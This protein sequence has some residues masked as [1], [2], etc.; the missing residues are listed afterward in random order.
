M[1]LALFASASL[2]AA[3]PPPRPSTL[4]LSVRNDSPLARNAEIAVGGVPLPRGLDI[5]ST[6]NLAVTTDSG[7]PIPATFRI[8][9]RWNAGLDDVSAPVQ[10]L[11]VRF[12]ASLPAQS[13]ASFRLRYDGSIANP[14]P[15]VSLTL[16]Q[17]GN[18]IT[19][20]TGTASFV[21]DGSAAQVL[22]SADLPNGTR[23]I[24]SGS[25]SST[26]NGSTAAGFTSLRRIVVEH[27][28]ALSAVV[29]VEGS[30]AHPQISNGAV[31]GGRR[32]VFHAGS[33]AVSVREW[34]DWEGS[35]CG[36]GTVSCAGA[37]DAV[38]LN[39]WR[40]GLTP[41]ALTGSRTLMSK[42]TI[43]QPSSS[44]A[45]AVGSTAALR[46][47]RR[48]N[49]QSAQQYSLSLPGSSTSAGERADAAV[50]ALSGNNGRVAI[51][52]KQ[53]A[54]HEPQALR[55][56]A[57]GTLALDLA[58]DGVWLGQRQGTSAEYRI[59][60]YPASSSDTSV[61]TEQWA[62]LEQP[63]L[64][65]PAA[66]W[67]AASEATDE[68]PV[69]TLPASLASY[70]SALANLITRTVQLRRERGLMGLM[71][72]GL[73]PRNWGNPVLLDE[74]DCGPDNDP[75]PA[76][77]WD[78]A[79]WCGF[80]SDYHNT[81]AMAAVHAWRQQDPAALH[82]I[83]FPAALRSLHTQM[84]RCAPDDPYFYCGQF[85]TG[86]GGFRADFNSS[87][88]Y[89]ENLI[90][91]YWMSGD[92]TV[93]ERL[94]NGAR[95][96]R[97]Y[98]CPARGG[99]TPGPVCG[100]NTP[101]SDEFAGV[102]DRVANQFYHQFRLLGLARDASFLDDWR[103]NTARFLTQN[104]ALIT[105]NG[106]SLGFTEPSGGGSTTII[107]GAGTYASTQLWMASIYDF[108]TL[109]RLRIDSNDA[110]LGNPTIAPSQAVHG[111]A[112]ALARIV[113]SVP[114]NGT[115]AGIMPNSVVYSFTGN[116]IGGTLT[117]LQ[118]GWSPGAMPNP[119]FDD[120]LYEEGKA[121]LAAGLARAA[122]D[123]NDA[124]LR[125][126][127]FQFSERALQ[128]IAL[129]PTPMGKSSGEFFG[130]LTSSVARLANSA[131]ADLLLVNG[132]E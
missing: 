131:P 76:D 87:H 110:P 83:A 104:F 106:Q 24:G 20:A 103:S 49:R 2:Q 47:L 21:L 72:F 19:I 77:D 17:S 78:D 34:I 111:W 123:Q 29:I 80:W 84:L 23:L 54:D 132:F 22:K 113:A 41:G 12:P 75:T 112:R 73:Y 71:T 10:W 70:D 74:I 86:Y 79:Y 60:I 35:R 53:M 126:L 102:N 93:L 14:L 52:L 120:C 90:L 43:Q 92:R 101:I 89:V 107:N 124:G 8:L 58:D 66:R 122:D 96:Y 56:L 118:P 105:S 95:N 116:R 39:R 33:S 63:L 59:G 37:P 4:Q 130:R 129:S 38:L 25:L 42:V 26:V 57:D 55:L 98:V 1:L 117:S 94:E 65:L 108:N 11:L 128:Q 82:T 69:D 45:A 46:Q 99:A 109:Q 48:T 51:S 44:V 13:S 121:T 9:A 32:L 127:A 97:A 40:L 6:Q 67:I 62:A 18:D 7:V 114:G 91:Y 125:A 88:A 15:A 31:S 85:P 30:F 36:L 61:L 68:F 28:D 5:R 119:C 115:A 3:W 16:Q 100:P 50:F 81:T 64:V 27:A